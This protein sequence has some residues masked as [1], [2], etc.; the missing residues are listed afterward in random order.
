M[1]QLQNLLMAIFVI[2]QVRNWLIAISSIIQNS[3][4][5]SG[6]QV[7]IYSVVL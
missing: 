4:S 6:L 5:A 2:G 1:I 7:I 3:L